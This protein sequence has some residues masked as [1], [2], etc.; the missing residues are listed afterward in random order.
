MSNASTSVAVIIPVHNGAGTITRQLDALSPQVDSENV[1]VLVIDNASTDDTVGVI[2]RWAVERH[3]VR[4]VHANDRPGAGYARNVGA[5]STAAEL[6][7]FCDADDVVG[8]GWVAGHVA[9]LA[10]APVSVGPVRNWS[11]DEPVDFS[12]Q[13]EG[14]WATFGPYP[15]LPGCNFG[16][17][18]ADFVALGGFDE[19]FLTAQDAELGVRATEA[20][21]AF[22]F[23]ADA[24]ILRG[25]SN[26]ARSRFRRSVQY[27]RGRRML[28]QK[29]PRFPGVH[30]ARD[31]L[32]VLARLPLAVV[33]EP[34]RTAVVRRL[35]RTIGYLMGGFKPGTQHLSH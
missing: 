4:V 28:R 20:G 11:E 6:L 24:R 2:E 33:S 16:I 18:A 10:T 34:H 35:G 21:Y 14:S 27:G 22:A 19:N 29:H 26:S 9:E 25:V 23:A 7:L 12:G 17:R 8:P 32:F 5:A 3:T 31:L 13:W 15:R 1:E 30:P